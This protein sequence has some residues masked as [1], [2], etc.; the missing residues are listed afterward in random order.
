MIQILF[1][2]VFIHT[3]ALLKMLHVNLAITLVRFVMVEQIQTVNFV[4]QHHIDI[5]KIQ[6]AYAS[7]IFMME[8]V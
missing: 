8:V 3:T 7:I 2:F 1:V 4:M 6:N 5:Y